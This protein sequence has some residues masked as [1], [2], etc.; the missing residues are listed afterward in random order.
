MQVLRPSR[1]LINH[2]WQAWRSI[3]NSH[4]DFKI[5]PTKIYVHTKQSMLKKCNTPNSHMK[6]AQTNTIKFFKI[7]TFYVV[8]DFYSHKTKAIK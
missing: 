7:F 3:Y 1:L 4:I 2:S 8:L 6:C 5:S